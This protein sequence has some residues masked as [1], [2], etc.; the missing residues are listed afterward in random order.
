M[1]ADLLFYNG[2]VITMD[3][4]AGVCEA[5]AVKDSKILS[6]GSNAEVGKL[7]GK[8]TKV[9]NLEGKTLMPGFIDAHAHLELYG[10]NALGVNGKVVK[11]IEELKEKLDAKVKNTPSGQW[12]RG[13]GYNQNYLAEGRHPTRWDLDQVSTEHPIILVR[14]CGHISVVNSKALE[15]AGVDENTTDPSGGKYVR[16]EKGV[17]IGV[18]REQAHM[19]MFL[20]A[21]YTDEEIM[22]GLK[23]ASSDYLSKGITSI[24]DAGG[25]DT[26]HFSFLFDA[27]EKG[28]IKQRVYVIYGGL[29][30]APSIV[31][32]G[33]EAG[34]KTGVGNNY[35]RIGPAK[36]FIDG[37]SSGPTAKTRQPYTSN[38]N[39]SGILYLNQEDLTKTLGDAHNQGWQ[40][41]AHAIGDEAVEMM[42]NC[43]EQV[44]QENPREDH[45]HRIEHACMTPPDLLKRM[46][47]LN[48]LPIP[49]PAFIYEFGDGYVKD[50]GERVE[51]MFPIESFLNEGIPAAI[52]SDSPITAYDPLIGIYAA[53]SRMSKSGRL[54]GPSQKT[55]L[56]EVLKM[57]TLNGAF[58]SFEDNIKG[59]LV[60]GK[61][62]DMVVLDQPILDTPIDQINNIEVEMTVLDGAIV[63][64]NKKEVIFND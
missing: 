44:L 13:W 34:I 6:V 20:T 15:I 24:H 27:I 35:F 11:S 30:D 28:L 58:A 63:F 49:N 48:I 4:N 23:I 41:T 2:Q 37:S 47:D 9:I 26:R 50:Y 18:L 32:K 57:Y 5:L 42:I 61:L 29:H 43:I 56:L 31:H 45:R 62:A 53:V 38:N 33:V 17:P 21:Q 14:T 54:V 60:S 36:V 52:G 64:Q 1:I 22:Q 59:S 3:N 55:D 16:D 25:Y 39:D 40:I 51:T 19:N 12:V 8:E 7:K 10:T 46:K